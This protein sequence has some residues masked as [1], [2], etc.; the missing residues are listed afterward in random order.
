[1]K[2]IKNY[3][4]FEATAQATEVVDIEIPKALK[5]ECEKAKELQ[6]RINEA[7]KEKEKYEKLIKDLDKEQTPLINKIEEGLNKI[8][9][10]SIMIEE[11]LFSLIV[12]TKRSSVKYAEVVKIIKESGKLNKKQMDFVEETQK[13]FTT[14]ASTYKELEI[15]F[16]DTV[17]ENA[18]TNFF[19]A[20]INKIKKWVDSFLSKVESLND[21]ANDLV[22]MAKT[23]SII[24]ESEAT[25]A[26]EEEKEKEEAK[27]VKMEVAENRA[28][29][30]EIANQVFDFSTKIRKK[31]QSIDVP[32]RHIDKVRTKFSEIEA[33]L[34]E[35]EKQFKKDGKNE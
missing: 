23:V 26:K 28:D 9:K 22:Y 27:E 11:V 12:K 31:L 34:D 32:F 16:N 10:D 24:K 2:F 7:L 6:G 14:E 15:K 18:V 5:A 13:R 3:K 33:I 1:M 8:K 29:L 19:N 35:I 20:F 4:M 30:K 17:K 21:E 25:E